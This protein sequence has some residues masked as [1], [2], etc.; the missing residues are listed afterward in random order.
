MRGRGHARLLYADLFA[1]SVAAGHDLVACE[2]NA[3]PPNPP[4]SAAFHD[5]LGFVEVG[6]G[7]VTDGKVVRYLT[8]RVP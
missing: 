6:R 4:A 3:E 1:R 7:E 5:A 8:R 2:V